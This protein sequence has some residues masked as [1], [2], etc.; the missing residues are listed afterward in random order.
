MGVG[1]RH[2][3]N[4]A[5]T[6]RDIMEEE[7]GPRSGA[8]VQCYMEHSTTALLTRSHG[9]Y[10]QCGARILDPASGRVLLWPAV[11]EDSRVLTKGLVPSKVL[12]KSKDNS[13]G[14]SK[15]HTYLM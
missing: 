14:F 7:I 9:L 11:P 8:G 1:G 15:S 3:Q 4:T 5:Q 10:G 13:V 6:L 12:L 2:S